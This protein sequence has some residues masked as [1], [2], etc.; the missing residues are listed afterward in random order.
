MGRRVIAVD[1]ANKPPSAAAEAAMKDESTDT[2]LAARALGPVRVTV[3]AK[4]WDKACDEYDRVV[5]KL[6]AD[7]PD[8]PA[9]WMARKIQSAAEMA[10]GYAHRLDV[11]ASLLSMR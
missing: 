10:Y 1:G 9:D 7:N 3:S 8:A 11:A 4:S 6:V 5:A 2:R